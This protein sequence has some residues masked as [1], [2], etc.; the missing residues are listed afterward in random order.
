MMP[1]QN[2]FNK[3]TELT[4][5]IMNSIWPK[6]PQQ[7]KFRQ[8]MQDKNSCK[9]KRHYTDQYMKFN[10]NTAN[11]VPSSL[12]SS[13]SSNCSSKTTSTTSTQSTQ[14][15][16]YAG[17]KFSEAPL[18]S[19][20]PKPPTH[21]IDTNELNNLNI[22][23]LD[24][25]NNNLTNLIQSKTVADA[26]KVI[27]ETI[28]ILDNSKQQKND[29]QD[30]KYYI[31]KTKQQQTTTTA[32]R[33]ESTTFQYNFRNTRKPQCQA[34]KCKNTRYSTFSRPNYQKIAAVN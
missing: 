16:F 32:T 28:E 24:E 26:K 15:P 23:Q 6:T 11:K 9:K 17:A 14:S 4:N 3:S 33:F 19:N 27:E 8:I 29:K 7:N 12:N 1:L 21:W 20:L 34:T 10:N 2:N 5:S 30:Q 13:F 22:N 31:N 25:L 18:P